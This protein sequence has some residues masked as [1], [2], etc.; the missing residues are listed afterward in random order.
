MQRDRLLEHATALGDYG[1]KRLQGMKE[2]YPIIGEV[3][4]KGLWLAA[5]FVKD[6]K[7]R[8]KNYEAAAQVNLH[9]LRN[10]LYYIHDSISWFV[11]LQP[12]LNIERA[13]FEQGMDILEDAMAR[14]NAAGPPRS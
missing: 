11:R 5:E 10:G 8:D 2:K 4:G 9:C 7:S 12:P 6:Q 1:L 14:V 13:L 3:R